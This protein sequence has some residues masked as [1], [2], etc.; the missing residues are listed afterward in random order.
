MRVSNSHY[1]NDFPEAGAI[2]MGW[3]VGKW[4]YLTEVRVYRL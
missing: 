3:V 4:N 1:L 2:K